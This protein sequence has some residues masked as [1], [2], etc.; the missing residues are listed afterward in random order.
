MSH[1]PYHILQYNLSSHRVILYNLGR[2]FWTAILSGSKYFGRFS[3]PGT[4]GEDSSEDNG[5]GYFFRLFQ[6]RD[7]FLLFLV[8]H[9][10]AW[11]CTQHLIFI[12]PIPSRR[13]SIAI[14]D[15]IPTVT[16]SLKQAAWAHREWPA[17][18]IK[19]YSPLTIHLDIC[20]WTSS[21][22]TAS[23]VDY[24]MSWAGKE[25]TTQLYCFQV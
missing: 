25:P 8:G 14:D 1:N 17:S 3:S 22:N 6:S 13:W 16:F 21:C 2:N 23:T 12:Y 4:P 20:W 19:R 7:R 10:F 15:R 24:A 9:F 18:V 5:F 11:N